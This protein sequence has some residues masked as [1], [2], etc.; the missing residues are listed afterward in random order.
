M[1]LSTPQPTLVLTDTHGVYIPQMWCS[2]LDQEQSK[3]IGVDWKDVQ[4]CQAGPNH[5]C[6]CDAWASILDSCAFTD[7]KGVKWTLHQDGDLWEVPE[8]FD[9]ENCQ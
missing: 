6:Y 3:A 5:E 2:D 7:A 8:G 1:T 4:T 9:F